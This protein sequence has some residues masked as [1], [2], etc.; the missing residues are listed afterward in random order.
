MLL[1]HTRKAVVVKHVHLKMLK[2]YLTD[3]AASDAPIMARG[4]ISA[5]STENRKKLKVD[6]DSISHI[7]PNQLIAWI[8]ADHYPPTANV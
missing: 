2:R 4:V 5:E 7:L 6:E 3:A 1:Y 8:F